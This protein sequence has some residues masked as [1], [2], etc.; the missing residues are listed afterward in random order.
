MPALLHDRYLEISPTHVCDL[1]TAD[2]F[3]TD[4]V[5][6]AAPH[7]P[8]LPSLLEVFDH[9]R[10]G[11]PRAVST[12]LRPPMRWRAAVD[13]IAADAAARGCVPIAVQVYVSLAPMARD[14]LAGRTLVLI[15]SERDVEASRRALLDAAT[16]SPRPHVLVTVRSGPAGTPS[17]VREARTAYVAPR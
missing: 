14:Q 11:R 3:A 8:V 10:D 16:S 6:A 12:T 7:E 13:R 2:V 5:R 17:A 9:G 15:A 4:A 1:A